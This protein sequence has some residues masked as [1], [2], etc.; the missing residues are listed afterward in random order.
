MIDAGFVVLTLPTSL[1]AMQLPATVS[2]A[3]MA[4]F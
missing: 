4:L 1:G 2:G 3:C